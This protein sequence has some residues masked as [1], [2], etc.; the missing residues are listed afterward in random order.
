MT[1]ENKGLKGPAIFLA[2]G[3]G[4]VGWSTLEE[5]ARTAAGLGYKGLQAQL[6]TGGPID[7]ELAAT[8]KAYC[9]DLQ[10]VAT[11]AGC[12][13][14][15]VANHCDTQLVR[16]CP[17]YLKLHSWPAPKHIHGNP[18]ALAEWAANRAKL[19]VAAAANFG[20]KNVAAFSGTGM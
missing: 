2:Q 12:P 10:A 7:L 14:V 5:C 15:E 1:T 8:S 13:I 20:F 18:V 19:S 6:W 11:N 3:W 4:K 16:C 9:D 17:A